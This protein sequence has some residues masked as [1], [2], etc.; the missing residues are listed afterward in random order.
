MNSLQEIWDKLNAKGLGTDKLSVHSYGEVYEQYFAPYRYKKFNL[1]EIGLF[2]GHSMRLWESYFMVA[3][4]HGID[5]SDQP[6][7]GLADLR[8][9]IKEGKHNIHILDATNEWELRK[10][11]RGMTFQFIIDDGNHNI[12]SQLHSY[13][14][15]SQYLTDTGIY[16]IED[17]ENIDET[18]ELFE[19]MDSTKQ[20]QILDRR[21]INKRFDDV[22]VVIQNRP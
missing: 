8:P 21:H 3:D 7:G 18:R 1:L 22:I 19:K 6:H 9:M 5:C 17:V 14:I 11:F 2:N 12:I 10:A 20:I 4:I 13:E 15:L 16:F